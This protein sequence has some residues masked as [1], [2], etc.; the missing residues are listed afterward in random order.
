MEMESEAHSLKQHLFI[1][2]GQE[3]ELIN[4]VVKIHNMWRDIELKLTDEIECKELT[5]EFIQQKA[6]EAYEI[7]RKILKV[8]NRIL[9]H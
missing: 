4:A 5:E 1:F 6:L 3:E 9:Y 8:F 2:F 7:E